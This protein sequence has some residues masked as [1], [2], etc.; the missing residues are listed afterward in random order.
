M[1]QPQQK[2]KQHPQASILG[3]LREE[4]GRRESHSQSLLIKSRILIEREATTLQATTMKAVM[5]VALLVLV[6]V[7]SMPQSVDACVGH[8]MRLPVFC[9][10]LR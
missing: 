6:A 9:L 1:K 4:G 2:A 8:G 7:A 10:R 5:I 3:Y